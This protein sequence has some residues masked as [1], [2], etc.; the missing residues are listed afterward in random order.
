MALEKQSTFYQEEDKKYKNGRRPKIAKIILGATELGS[1][2]DRETSRNILYEFITRHNLNETVYIDTSSVYGRGQ[3]EKS[4]SMIQ[5]LD[6]TQRAKSNVAIST[7]VH[8]LKGLDADGVNSQFQTSLLRMNINKIDILYIHQPSTKYAILPTLVAIN[9]LYKEGKIKRFGLCNFPS[10][11]VCEVVYLC[12]KYKLI[13]PTVYQGRYNPLRREIESELLPC[14]RHFNM[15]FYAFS[16]L[17]RGILTGKHKY[18]D[19]E[20]NTLKSGKFTFKGP[21]KVLHFYDYWKKTYF[22]GVDVV[23]AALKRSNNKKMNDMTMIEATYSWLLFHSKLDANKGDGII[24][25]CSKLYHVTSNLKLLRNA[26]LLD[27]DIVYAFDQAWNQYA[28]RD[29]DGYFRPY[30]RVRQIIKG[31][32]TSKL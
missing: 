15:A 24:F 7:K 6:I 3:S 4:L 13:S 1:N 2:V 21:K 17:A 19:L 30:E 11:M 26:Q 28:K 20:N 14:I 16:P 29:A 10:W 23:M 8:A 31:P 12:D 5:S 9:E 32:Q 27:D 18:E 22:Q 25:G